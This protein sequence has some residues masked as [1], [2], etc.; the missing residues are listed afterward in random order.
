MVFPEPSAFVKL[1][2]QLSLQNALLKNAAEIMAVA[3]FGK[4]AVCRSQKP[5]F[6]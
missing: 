5:S 2:R 4:R 3:I 6:A 1:R